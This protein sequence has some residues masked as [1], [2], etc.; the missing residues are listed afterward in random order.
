[1]KFDTLPT[2]WGWEPNAKPFQGGLPRA[3][4]DTERRNSPQG[5]CTKAEK[6]SIFYYFRL[7]GISNFLQ[8]RKFRFLEN[9]PKI[10]A[11]AEK[12][13][14]HLLVD[15]SWKKK[16]KL[17]GLFFRVLRKAIS[18]NIKRQFFSVVVKFKT[19]VYSL[20][21]SNNSIQQICVTK[22]WTNEIRCGSNKFMD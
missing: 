22:S 18:N 2:P 1:M 11:W 16:K 7:F 21:N 3:E 10:A 8:F 4:I 5:F 15:I 6:K 19:I 13:S 14:G 17:F 20:S 12:F 9:D